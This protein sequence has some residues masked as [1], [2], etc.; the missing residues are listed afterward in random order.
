MTHSLLT[1]G[2]TSDYV[3]H[4]IRRHTKITYRHGAQVKVDPVMSWL[5]LG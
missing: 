1:T 3:N 4:K 5:V 2:A